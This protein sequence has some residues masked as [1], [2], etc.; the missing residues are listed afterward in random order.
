MIA[1]RQRLLGEVAK[2]ADQP[3]RFA[4][5]IA[6]HRQS[7]PLAILLSPLLPFDN[8]DQLCMGVAEAV[9]HGSKQVEELF[10]IAYLRELRPRRRNARRPVD[11]AFLKESIVIADQPGED[12]EIRGVIIRRHAETAF[13][14]TAQAIENNLRIVG[15]EL[16]C[17]PLT[18]RTGSEIAV[19]QRQTVGC[20]FRRFGC[21][22]AVGAIVVIAGQA[23]FSNVQDVS[24][25]A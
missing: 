15:Q 5:P 25:A 21:R 20:A 13:W 12:V 10:I 18:I 23:V 17:R 7:L 9:D 19:F 2:N 24:I 3:W 4:D 11:F 8:S 16:K 14:Q 1:G 22:K 6:D